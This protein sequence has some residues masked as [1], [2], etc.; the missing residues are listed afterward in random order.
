MKAPSAPRHVSLAVPG[1]PGPRGPLPDFDHANWN[2]EHFGIKGESVRIGRDA[3]TRN[4]LLAHVRRL[5]GMPEPS[6]SHLTITEFQARMAKPKRLP[7]P[8]QFVLKLLE[9]WRLEKHDVVGLLGFGQADTAHVAAVLDGKEHFRGRDVRDR[10]A[11]LFRIR[12]TLRVLFRDL[13]V[14]N[15]WLRESHS[16]LD[17]QSPLSLLSGGSMEDLLL[18][19]EYVDTV[20]GR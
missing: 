20:A 3:D 16:L 19:K 10:I 18:V 12:E 4:D 2:W 15:E 13:K 8:I 7:G 6:G 11:Y 1:E 14:E 9:Y 5:T 17:D